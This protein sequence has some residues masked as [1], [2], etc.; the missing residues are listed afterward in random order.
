MKVIGII[1]IAF[2]LALSV[3]ILYSALVAASDADDIEEQALE[4]ERKRHAERFWE[5]KGDE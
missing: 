2:W 1:L 5:D 3:L 4:Q